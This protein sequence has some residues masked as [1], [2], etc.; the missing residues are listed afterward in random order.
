MIEVP[1]HLAIDGVKRIKIYYEKSKLLGNIFTVCLL[2]GDNDELLARG[3]AICSLKDS[4]KKSS[5]KN[6]ALGRAT[7]AL[8]KHENLEK[9]NPQRDILNQAIVK[10]IS[11][12]SP[13]YKEILNEISEYNLNDFAYAIKYKGEDHLRVEI[14]LYIPIDETNKYFEYKSEYKPTPTVQEIRIIGK[15]NLAK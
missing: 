7:K 13:H 3:V 14:P 8:K 6:I 10:M 4:H 1:G 5:G 15:K 12:N 11:I 9:I 2:L